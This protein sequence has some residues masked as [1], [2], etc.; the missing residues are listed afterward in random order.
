MK[1]TTVRRVLLR[2]NSWAST[3]NRGSVSGTVNSE[4]FGGCWSRIV[5]GGCTGRFIAALCASA[6]GSCRSSIDSNNDTAAADI[7]R[8]N[9]RKQCRK[10]VL[11]TSRQRR[12]HR[13]NSQFFREDNDHDDD[14]DTGE[15][16]CSWV[17][18]SCATPP[19][20]LGSICSP[21]IAERT[22]ANTHPYRCSIQRVNKRTPQSRQQPKVRATLRCC[23]SSVLRT[24]YERPL[25][26]SRRKPSHLSVVQRYRYRL[27][28]RKLLA[29]GGTLQ[30]QGK[31]LNHCAIASSAVLVVRSPSSSCG[32]CR[33]D[34]VFRRPT[35]IYS[36]DGL[37]HGLCLFQSSR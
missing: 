32:R 3:C 29:A 12:R 6:G 24:R 7:E 37:H 13:H 14:D 5:G 19:H 36:N 2:R 4:R 1:V 33:F 30:Q 21:L 11:A 20:P 23:S 16:H 9:Q 25:V 31:R 15:Y 27:S 8:P 18:C 28:R 35:T 10:V 26:S 34:R 17:H 22:E